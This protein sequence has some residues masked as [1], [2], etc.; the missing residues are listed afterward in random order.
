M[1]L[2]ILLLA[3]VIAALY[4]V[5]QMAATLRKRKNTWLRRMFALFMVLPVWFLTRFLPYWWGTGLGTW[6]YSWLAFS[7]M[8]GAIVAGAIALGLPFV[9]ARR[10][11]KIVVAIGAL[12]A[13]FALVD[14]PWVVAWTLWRT[15]WMLLAGM[16]LLWLLF[17]ALG[18]SRL[19]SAYRA[20]T[21]VLLIAITAIGVGGL[22]QKW[23]HNWLYGLPVMVLVVLVGFVLY[24][25]QH[26]RR[27]WFVGISIGAVL[28]AIALVM[29]SLL[30]GTPHT[31]NAAI[32][33]PEPKASASPSSSASAHP[34][35][36]ASAACT[37]W[38]M[39]AG[40]PADGDLLPGGSPAIAAANTDAEAQAAVQE[41]LKK[42]RGYTGLL[43][44][45]AAFLLNKQVDPTTL[46][47]GGC[48]T[49][50]AVQLYNELAAAVTL[51]HV[52]PS[53]VPS[54]AYNSSAKNGVVVASTTP[55]ITG[56][57]LAAA[58]V[59][60]RD[61]TVVYVMAR[62]ANFST[63]G[64]PKVTPT[65]ARTQPPAAPHTTPP[66]VH[67]TPPVVHTTPPV[68]HTTPPQKSRPVIVQLTNLNEVQ[69]GQQSKQLCVSFILSKGD[70]GTV[71]FGSDI[72]G[73]TTASFKV[74]GTG[75]TQQECPTYIA[76]NDSTITKPNT[77][78]DT[79]TVTI[80]AG[81][82]TAQK[83]TKPFWIQPKPSDGNRG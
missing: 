77:V 19:A 27:W 76:P 3:E 12:V 65:P 11:R 39:L 2:L 38:P 57:N 45:A 64:R 71:S 6:K 44:G 16:V 74:T 83:S 75:G 13:A 50:A 53:D 58:Q 42:D 34:S 4:V 62:C 28:T 31:A 23:T 52:T 40:T 10:L 9:L 48:A 56:S 63:P 73:F 69:V 60:T 72:G 7:I 43:S 17:P 29:F 22:V 41:V 51:S 1:S 25:V 46:I 80:S 67:T 33:R 68:V 54:S 24:L 21:T 35:A 70:K 78:T 61:G 79:I 37:T 26:G 81:G 66:V 18:R 59:T 5:G 55:G 15:W 82:G 47:Q 8:A 32:D 49:P 14:H 20:M 30:G 36:S